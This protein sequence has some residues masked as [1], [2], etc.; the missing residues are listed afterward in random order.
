MIYWIWLTQLRGIGPVKQR[1][2][3]D[4]FESPE[5]VFRGTERELKECSGIG[6]KLARRIIESRSLEEAKRIMEKV[7]KNEL[8]IMT[9]DDSLYLDSVKEIPSTPL[10]LYYQ[11]RLP[12]NKKR[13]AVLGT[14]DCSSYGKKVAQ[15][16]GSFLANHHLCLVTGMSKGIESHTQSSF[17]R[18]GGETLAIVPHG[19]DVC[20]PLENQ[21]WRDEILAHGAVLSEFPPGRRPNPRLFLIRNRLLAAWSNTILVVEAKE[22]STCLPMA[23]Y[24]KEYKREVLAVPNS[25]YQEESTGSNRLIAEGAGIFIDGYQLLPEEEIEETEDVVGRPWYRAGVHYIEEPLN[26]SL[27][28]L[29]SKEDREEE[30]I[31]KVLKESQKKSIEELSSHMGIDSMSLVETLITMDLEGLVEVH[32]S[33]VVPSTP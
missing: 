13:V 15:D 3:L 22:K 16:V 26:R 17:L 28:D 23:Q 9:I 6:T 18:A 11:G 12:S 10:L 20:Y 14:R 32:G 33:I 8:Q 19:P 30:K 21:E 7:E 5:E 24:G 27:V 2:L 31:L 4:Y 29:D 1:S 25:I